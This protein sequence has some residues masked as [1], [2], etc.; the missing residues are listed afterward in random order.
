MLPCSKKLQVLAHSMI[1][2]VFSENKEFS[3]TFS[4]KS[5][6]KRQNMVLEKLRVFVGKVASF[7]Q[8][9]DFSCFFTK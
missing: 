1:F 9:D 7:R 4:L 3:A 2:K 8:I 5:S 6:P